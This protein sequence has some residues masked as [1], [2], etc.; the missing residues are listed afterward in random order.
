LRHPS[1]HDAFRPAMW[2]AEIQRSLLTTVGQLHFQARHA[3]Q[4]DPATGHNVEMR[5]RHPAYHV[6]TA[7]AALLWLVEHAH[8]SSDS[9]MGNALATTAF[10]LL[11]YSFP[12]G[13]F[14]DPE[15]VET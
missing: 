8:D 11:S 14:P 9:A 3:L 12:D 7:S 1:V 4:L 10:M 2:S 13:L 15:R 6:E 5:L